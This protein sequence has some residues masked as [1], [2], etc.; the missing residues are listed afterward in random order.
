[1]TWED[2]LL[3]AS[4][5]RIPAFAGMTGE[6]VGMTWEDHLLHASG[7]RIP[8]FAGMTGECVGMTGGETPRARAC[9]H[10]HTRVS[11]GFCRIL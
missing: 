3:H 11:V 10:A 4:G 7:T 2:H 1:M 6:C 9:A 8:A 5:T